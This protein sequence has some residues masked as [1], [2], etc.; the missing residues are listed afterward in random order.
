MDITKLWQSF[1]NMLPTLIKG[2]IL[3]LVAWLLAIL[4]KYLITKGFK[5]T[6]LD[7]YFVKWNIFTNMEQADAL[8]TA[9]GKIFYYL[10][11][12]LFL[13]GIFTTFGLDSIASPITDMMNYILSY[14][15]NILLAAVLLTIGFLVAKLVKNL[16]YNLAATL[17]VDHYI[18]KFVGTSPNKDTKDSIANV[19][20][21]VCYL[22]V[23][24]PIAIVALEALKI[25]TITKPLVTVLNSILAAIPDI[26]V[27]VILLAVGIVIA[28]VAGNLVT[29]LLANTGIDKMAAEAYP[30]GKAPTTA[31]SKILGQVVAAIVGL[32]FVVEALHALKLEVLDTVGKAIIS[33]LPNLLFAVIILGLGFFGGQFVGKVLTNATKNKWLGMIT[34]VVFGIFAVFMALDQL[35]FAN[36]IVNTAFL[37]IVGGLAVAFALAFGLGGRDFA[38]NQLEK[39]DHKLSDQTNENDNGN[40]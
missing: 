11:W 19:V 26:L 8:I 14:L 30:K 15:P 2:L 33:Y 29:S 3:I 18:D 9:L 4:I 24:I 17:K 27:A 16:V 7:R 10:V 36:S 40:K 6:H 22:L 12:L 20:A 35:D 13:P 25:S 21:M 5:K 37:F 1:Q 39:L 34:Q 32:F 23:L 31:L 28:K 38:H